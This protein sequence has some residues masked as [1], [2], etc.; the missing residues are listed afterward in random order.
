MT[1]RS[2]LIIR[3]AI[4]T[5]CSARGILGQNFTI[6]TQWSNTQSN[7][8]RSVRQALSNGAAQEL[9]VRSTQQELDTQKNAITNLASLA[10]ALATHDLF[11]NSS[12]SSDSVGNVL[13]TYDQSITFNIDLAN[14][15][16]AELSAAQAY[17]DGDDIR[18][19]YTIWDRWGAIY[20]DSFI[21]PTMATSNTFPRN[22][23]TTPDCGRTLGGM[24]FGIDDR[25]SLDVY[26]RALS[27]WILLSSRL[28]DLDTV[29]QAQYL[30]AAEL[31]IQFMTS[32]L[33]DLTAQGSD[34]VAHTFNASACKPSVGSSQ[35]RDLAPLIEGVS[36]VANLTRNDTYAQLLSEL[37]PLAVIGW[38]NPDGIMYESGGNLGK[39]YMIRSLLEA[40]RRNPTNTAMISLIDAFITVQFNAV[41]TN[42]NLS[43]NNYNNFWA[44]NSSPSSSYDLLGSIQALG[45]F[46]AASEIAPPNSTSKPSTNVGVIVGAVVGG[47]AGVTTC[48][49]VVL[50]CC[51]WRR[52]RRRPM[53]DNGTE[54]LSRARSHSGIEP[55][56]LTTSERTRRQTGLK[57]GTSYS[58]MEDSSAAGGIDTMAPSSSEEP[59]AP[60][61]SP[62]DISG[63]ARRINHLINVLAVRNEAEELPP[64]YE[65]RAS[66]SNVA[67]R[68]S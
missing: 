36:I 48:A 33:L 29:N 18:P 5:L 66:R 25:S 47:V 32:H 12:S 65:A 19:D 10:Q 67:S 43:N 68:S 34:I 40:R 14:F 41:R 21:T 2:S 50:V 44:G 46:D 57:G 52:S 59:T 22:L 56:L 9:R 64:G 38:S 8:S 31:S 11:S 13:Q 51:R 16:L 24:I 61:Q 62:D 26:T 6:P 35:S 60:V 58:R 17:G 42:A 54:L 7:A 4:T 49:L 27:V 3:V 1:H 15:G 28:A 20:N 45:V 39:G 37:I 30:Q 55:Y 53:S 63:L 23:S